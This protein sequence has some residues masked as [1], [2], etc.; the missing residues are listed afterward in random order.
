MKIIVEVD[1]TN[2]TCKVLSKSDLSPKDIANIVCDYFGVSYAELIEEPI[3]R[4]EDYRICR[5]LAALLI[6][7]IIEGT[8]HKTIARLLNYSDIS[9]ATNAMGTAVKEIE[10]QNP[11][12]VRPANNIIKLLDVY[13]IK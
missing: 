3:S 11:K 8:T 13:T 9:G 5:Q 4:K 7:N 1:L 12:Y 10:Q 2:N 6:Y